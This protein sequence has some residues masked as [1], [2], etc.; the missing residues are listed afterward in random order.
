MKPIIKF[1]AFILFAALVLFT[2]C[3]KTPFVQQVITPPPPPL[4]GNRAPIANAGVDQTI[5]LLID[6]LFLNG[7]L[8]SALHLWSKDNDSSV[9]IRETDLSP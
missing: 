9:A 2:S 3:K 6:S 7:S 4:I 1:T 5:N 8:S